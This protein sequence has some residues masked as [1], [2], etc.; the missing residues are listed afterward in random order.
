[1]AT[2][3]R[4]ALLAA[5][6]AVPFAAR[7][8]QDFPNRPIRLIVTFPPGGSS[9]IIGRLLSPRIEARLGQPLIIDNRPGA[10]GNIGIDAVAKAPPDG[11][12]LGIAAAG[13]LAVNPSLYPRMPY[14]VARDLAPITL[15]AGIPFVLAAAQSVPAA[16]LAEL[17]ARLPSRPPL[18]IGHGGNG[19]AMH[20]SAELFNQ[21][22][23][24]GLT[25]VPFR[26]TAPALAAV[27]AGQTDL[28]ILDIP[29][30]G[31][32]IRDGRLRA[33]AVTS[34]ARV[35][36]LPNVPTFAEAGLPGYESVGWFGLVAPAAT[37][38]PIL[39]RLNTAFTEALREPDIAARIETLGAVPM[40]STAE[41]FAAY[42]RSETSKWAEVVR[43][44]GAR[45]E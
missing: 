27:L 29:S 30:S 40:P 18:T 24:A 44:S 4:R 17:R 32:L 12:T 31:E 19:T 26:G 42:I 41:A 11:H 20:L 39:A 23:A 22:A 8:Q 5:P 2:I 7:A 14:D 34:P 16:T 9:D 13:A 6:L 45:V 38:A 25:A 3:A 15:V 1:M 43:V 36:S 10:G 21:M 28:A 33:L 37:P 35:P